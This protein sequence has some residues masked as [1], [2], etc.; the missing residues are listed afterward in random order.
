VTLAIVGYADRMSVRPGDI[1]NV[2]VSCES[3]A[4][5]YR[6]DLVRLI[7]G[8][9]SPNGPGYKERAVE[10]PANGE[11]AGRRQRINAG[12][13][14][15][16]PPSP[17]LQALSSFTLEAL[18]W[19]T[20]PGRGTQTLL[21]RWDEAGQAGYALILDATGAV[22]LRLGDGSSETFS[23]AAPLD[24]RTWYLV[25]AS[26]DAQ[27]KGVRVTQ[28]PLRQ[29][30]RDPSAATLATT[31]RVVPKAPTA[32]PFLMAAHVVGE[33]AGR[34]V[35]AGHYNGKIEAP[36]LS[37]RALAPGEA[38][39]LVAAWDFAREIPGDEI[40]DVSGNGLDGVAVNLPAR[41]MKGH[42]WNGEVHR[43]S[44]KPEHYAAIHF[45]D[46]DL[47]DAR[48]EPDFEVAIPQDMKSGIYAVKLTAGEPREDGGHEGFVTF[49]VLPPK[50]K[51][52]APVA[53]LAST[54]TYMAYANSHHGWDDP[55]AEITYGS[56]LEFGPTS[57]FLN[58]R[59]EFG[60]ST[61]DVHTDGSGSCY[62][63][64]L[65]PILNTRPKYS[66]WNFNADLHIIDWL[67]ASGQACDVITDEELHAEGLSILKPYRAV[68]TG[69]HPEY[70]TRR[71]FQTVDDYLQGGGRLMYLGGN[72]FYWRIAF[73]PEKPGVIEMRRGESGTRTW[74]AEAGEYYLS[75]TG[76]MSG[77]WRAS[78]WSSHRLVGISFG[79]EGFDVSS[80]YRRQP[81]SF[82]PRAAF[83]FEG[84]SADEKIGDFG[85][86]GGGAAGLELDIVDPRLGTPPHT[87]VLASSENH[88][89]V[90]LM[91][92]EEI[93]STYPGLDGIEDPRVRADMVFFET[94]NGGAVFST[95][96][97]AWAGSLGHNGY[98]NNVARITGNV[99]QRFIDPTPL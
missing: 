41:A 43:W 34:L 7:C 52:T 99:L 8:D 82:D 35:A 13:Y 67:E 10:H 18:I 90:Y 83:I 50:G 12:S 11:Y 97:I 44:E 17:A 95:G 16:V 87:L 94:P 80:Y 51:A 79:S 6:A 75:F 4:A 30:A 33:Q 47:Y 74:I 5:S 73:H 40:L 53:F 65:R 96:S 24:T 63:S 54:A 88:S 66:L 85:G 64:R 98:A 86:V 62:S 89:N 70:H 92:P 57:L 46:D 45:H 20:T 2:M 84:I 1:L 59:R 23:T 28:Q 72:G 14:V 81:G 36:R 15:R 42:L 71:M 69:T 26:Y 38:G 31:A 19:P 21:G 78:G 39:N 76:E 29:R 91:T 58:A 61:Y 60:V 93:I 56:L 22:A 25:S 48:W 49:F 77:M 9:D 55:L 3:G 68:L 27:T 32:T 37:R